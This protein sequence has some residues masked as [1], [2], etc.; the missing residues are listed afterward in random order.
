MAVTVR[1]RCLAEAIAVGIGEFCI[2]TQAMVE[3]LE[4]VQFTPAASFSDHVL[5]KRPSSYSEAARPSGPLCLPFRCLG[6]YS[7]L[8][9]T[10]ASRSTRCRRLD[11]SRL[12]QL[13]HRSICSTVFKYV[14]ITRCAGSC[15]KM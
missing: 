7:A 12:K 9:S 13:A 15:W 4:D 5:S 11:G 8:G 3:S 1:V 10:A 6:C 2:E 14:K